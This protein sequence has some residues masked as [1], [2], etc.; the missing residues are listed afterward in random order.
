MAASP[1]AQKR[2]SIL[3][4]QGHRL[5]NRTHLASNPTSATGLGARLLFFWFLLS[6]RWYWR[7]SKGLTGLERRHV[8]PPVHISTNQFLPWTLNGVTIFFV[9]LI[10]LLIFLFSS[11]HWEAKHNSRHLPNNCEGH[12]ESVFSL[13]FLTFVFYLAF[14][15]LMV[16]CCILRTLSENIP[17]TVNTLSYLWQIQNFPCK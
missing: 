6:Q 4:Q 16:P 11:D 14:D 1:Y 2:N 10:Y 12:S 7:L 3:Q 15:H 17:T 5:G 9:L 8:M 13:F